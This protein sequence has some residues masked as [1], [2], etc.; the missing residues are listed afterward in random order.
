VRTLIV[1]LIFSGLA[2]RFGPVTCAPA[3]D[4]LS[5]ALCT[6]I[7]LISAAFGRQTGM[8]NLLSKKERNITGAKEPKR[9][10]PRG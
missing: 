6:S 9:G 2:P 7:F 8:Q 3:A 4:K 1:L 5:A 10:N